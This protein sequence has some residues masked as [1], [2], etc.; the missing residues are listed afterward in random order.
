MIYGKKH[1]FTV[2]LLLTLL[3]VG[4]K[5]S[6]KSDTKESTPLKI[7]TF[8]TN[9]TGN[10]LVENGSVDFEKAVTYDIPLKEKPIWLLYTECKGDPILVATLADGS[11]KAWKTKGAKAEA[12]PFTVTKADGAIENSSRTPFMLDTAA[13]PPLTFNND[14]GI[15]LLAPPKDMSPHSTHALLPLSGKTA[16]I[17]NDGVLVILGKEETDTLAIDALPDA[18]I[19]VDEKDRIALYTAPTDRY[20]HAVLGDAIEPA[21]LTLIATDSTPRVLQ[22]IVLDSPSVFEGLAPHWADIHPAE[23]REF[24][25]T[26]SHPDSGSYMAVYSEAGDF[27]GQGPAIGTGNRWK[28]L[29]AADEKSNSFA[30]VSMPHGPGDV[31]YYEMTD[32][33]LKI[34]SAKWTQFTSHGMHSRNLSRGLGFRTPEDEFQL[35]LTNKKRD[36]IA[37]HRL[38][39]VDVITKVPVGGELE[40]NIVGTVSKDGTTFVAVGSDAG[41]RIWEMKKK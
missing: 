14:S 2:L 23:G 11:A 19:L 1:V 31:E 30:V 16:Y 25:T 35:I 39:P 20:K 41:I 40:T 4:C 24:I 26:I 13:V 28:H 32:S 21:G 34:T 7:G 33:T 3:L 37:H 6:N 17:R 8:M 38:K 10:K 22:K 5:K 18:R 36:T 15:H 9:T 12:Y 27:L 29:I